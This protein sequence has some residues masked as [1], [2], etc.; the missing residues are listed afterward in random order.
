MNAGGSG[1]A[2]GAIHL[3]RLSGNK[4]GADGGLPQGKRTVFS[5]DDMDD[6]DLQACRSAKTYWFPHQCTC[7]Q[8]ITT[9]ARRCNLPCCKARC[10]VCMQGM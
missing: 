8:G 7:A 6:F 9:S 10:C 3:G 2:G 5:G 4:A 1:G